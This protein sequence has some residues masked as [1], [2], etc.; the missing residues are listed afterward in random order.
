MLVLLQLVSQIAALLL[1]ISGPKCIEPIKLLLVGSWCEEREQS[2]VTD[3][4]GCAGGELVRQDHPP[5]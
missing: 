1:V 2:V 3:R 5:H 4:H